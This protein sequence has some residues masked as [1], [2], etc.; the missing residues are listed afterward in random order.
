M[1]SAT[2]RVSRLLSLPPK[3]FEMPLTA[4]PK[5]MV[6]ISPPLAHTG[7]GPILVRLISYDLREGQ[8]GPLP[9][10]ARNK[11]GAGA[12]GHR[13]SSYQMPPLPRPHPVSLST[14]PWWGEA[15]AGHCSLTRILLPHPP[16]QRGAQQPGEVRGSVEPGAS[17]TAPAGTPLT[18][19]DSAYPRWRLC[20][21]DLQVP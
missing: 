13:Q 8:V 16:E 1:A 9:A 17:A 19:P 12:E 7:P 20:G 14:C 2:V 5:L 10:S 6:T 21:P 3:A 11:Y 18:F 15:P 4:D